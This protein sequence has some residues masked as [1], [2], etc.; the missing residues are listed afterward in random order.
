[1]S[2]RG[3]DDVKGGR[4]GMNCMMGCR[5]GGG[6]DVGGRRT[7]MFISR[8]PPVGW[9][10][11]PATDSPAKRVTHF[12]ISDKNIAIWFQCVC[13][14]LYVIIKFKRNMFFQI[15]FFFDVMFSC[16]RQTKATAS[17]GHW[18]QVA[19][20]RL[21]TAFR[22]YLRGWGRLT[23]GVGRDGGVTRAGEA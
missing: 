18:R 1:M 20:P 10:G 4:G 6:D 15:Q 16:C 23:P 21:G 13:T 14:Y 19:N 3:L 22:A 8:A 5:E 12:F 7:A 17:G 11:P 2:S 9:L